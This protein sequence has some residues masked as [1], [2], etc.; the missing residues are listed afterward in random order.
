MLGEG[1][2]WGEGEK[3]E[4]HGVR[5]LTQRNSYNCQC[6]FTKCLQVNG[7]WNGLMGSK[8]LKKKKSLKQAFLLFGRT[9]Y[10]CHLPP[11]PLFNV[12]FAWNA[13]V[14]LWWLCS[15]LFF[16]PATL[17]W[18][19][20]LTWCRYTKPYLHPIFLLRDPLNCLNSL[21]K[22][23]SLGKENCFI[24]RVFR[25]L[26]AYLPLWLS[27]CCVDCDLSKDEMR[28]QIT[29]PLVNP[30]SSFFAS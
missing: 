27:L 23:H 4:G 18:I 15:H 16:F 29:F 1:E 30:R 12:C 8:A 20:S 24:S 13:V 6:C 25:F 9:R 7:K 3:R 14:V 5:A 21:W 10:I 22:T 17:P 11:T 19:Y 26:C 28:A 2:C